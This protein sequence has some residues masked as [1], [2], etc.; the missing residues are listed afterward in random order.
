MT[1]QSKCTHVP[2]PRSVLSP[3]DEPLFDPKDGHGARSWRD[4]LILRQWK[5]AVE[6]DDEALADLASLVVKENLAELRRARGTTRVIG[7]KVRRQQIRTLIPA[8]EVLGMIKTETIE[9]APERDK[10]ATV[11]KRKRILFEERF[12]D[13]VFGREGLDPGCVAEAREWIANGAIQRRGFTR[14]MLD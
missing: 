6:G 4:V 3:L 11:T 13:Y 5:A 10:N 7:G 12:L 8:M 2:L 1:R 14:E 9:V